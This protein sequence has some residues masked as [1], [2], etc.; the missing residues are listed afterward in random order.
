MLIKPGWESRHLK[1]SVGGTDWMQ[2][3]SSAKAMLENRCRRGREDP[4][5]QSGNMLQMDRSKC[6]GEEEIL[7][8]EGRE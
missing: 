2:A 8:D 1:S 7:S 3:E 6:A 5:I 4:Q